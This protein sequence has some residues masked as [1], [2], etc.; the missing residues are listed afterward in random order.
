MKYLRIL[1]LSVVVTPAF[2]ALMM[3]AACS[4][5]AGAKPDAAAFKASD[6]KDLRGAPAWDIAQWKDRT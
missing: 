2:A 6:A 4:D 3:S 1:G 5:T